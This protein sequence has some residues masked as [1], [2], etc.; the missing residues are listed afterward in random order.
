MLV[1]NEVFSGMCVLLHYCVAAGQSKWFLLSV[2]LGLSILAM[3]SKEQGITALALCL[4]Y[5]LFIFNQVT[6]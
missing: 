6:S 2:S 4:I 5:D 1:A 3:L